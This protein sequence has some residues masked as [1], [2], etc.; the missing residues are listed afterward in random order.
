MRCARYL[1]AALFLGSIG[2]ARAQSV[3]PGNQNETQVRCKDGTTGT[4]GRG[5]S[6][7]H[8]G[9]AKNEGAPTPTKQTPATVGADE[10]KKVAPA[11]AATGAPVLVRC[12]DGRV[13]E[14]AASACARNGG[15][16]KSSL[17]THPIRG[18]GPSPSERVNAA[19]NSK[20]ELSTTPPATVGTATAKCK[21]GTLSYSLHHSGTC[22]GHG[23]VA[24]WLEPQP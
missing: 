13:M 3:D 22:S 15:L 17:A 7:Q 23:G 10:D 20:A 18:T 5:A 8:G 16:D 4:A 24:Q 6:S 12:K 2:V 9:V 21:D 19:P 14:Q 11:T 1:A